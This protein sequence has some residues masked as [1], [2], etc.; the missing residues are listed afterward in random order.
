MLH[1]LYIHAL[2]YVFIYLLYIGR[3][4]T[5]V[6]LRAAVMVTWAYSLQTVL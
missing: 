3:V 6:A 1:M 5:R 2:Y 4:A